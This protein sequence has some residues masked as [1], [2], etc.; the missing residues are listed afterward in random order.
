MEILENFRK[1]EDEIRSKTAEEVVLVGV[2]KFQSIEKMQSA[3]DAGLRHFGENRVQEGLKKK[4]SLPQN[5]TWHLIGHL[6]KNKARQAVQV[7]D[8]IH[9]VDS[10]ELAKILDQEAEKQG[11]KPKILIQVNVAQE[12]QKYGVTEEELFDVA[13]QIGELSHLEV[14]G[15]MVMAPFEEEIEKVRPVFKRGRELFL[16]LQEVHKSSTIAFLSMGMSNDYPI[17]IE[18]GA[19]VIRV[20]RVLFENLQ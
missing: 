8:W 9:S 10:Y 18:E 6:Q 16:K 17:A 4:K 20:G 5:A 11:K 2:S 3:W 13:K 1:I 15:I 7:F 12:P 19:N 14:V